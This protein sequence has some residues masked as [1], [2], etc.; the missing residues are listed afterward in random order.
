[1]LTKNKLFYIDTD[2]THLRKFDTVTFDAVKIQLNSG[3]ITEIC[4]TARGSS[5]LLCLIRDGRLVSFD[6]FLG[7]SSLELEFSEPCSL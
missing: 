1:M 6:T 5:K 2:K 7:T 3:E 4:P